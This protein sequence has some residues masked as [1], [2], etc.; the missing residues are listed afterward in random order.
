MPNSNHQLNRLA[1]SEAILAQT[2]P[3]QQANTV[4]IAQLRTSVLYCMLAPEFYSQGQSLTSRGI[5]FSDT[6]FI[7]LDLLQATT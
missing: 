3:Q 2:A 5:K 1:Q 4:A 7:R 6:L